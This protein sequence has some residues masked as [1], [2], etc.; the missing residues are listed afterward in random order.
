[1]LSKR[2][3]EINNVLHMSV[4]SMLISSVLG[5]FVWLLGEIMTIINLGILVSALLMVAFFIYQ[6]IHHLFGLKKI[7]RSIFTTSLERAIEI[8]LEPFSRKIGAQDLSPKTTQLL[9]LVYLGILVITTMTI[10]QV[11]S[12]SLLALS[13]LYLG[14]SIGAENFEFIVIAT[15]VFSGLV[16][17]SGRDQI[18]WKVLHQ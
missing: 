3:S 9:S 6:N 5:R 10:L 17:S 1:M 15:A 7:D 12:M 16:M 11:F 4:M 18:S 14:A 13:E 2:L 8:V